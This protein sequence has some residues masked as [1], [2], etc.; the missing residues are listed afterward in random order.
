[1]YKILRR[2]MFKE[3]DV[4]FVKKAIFFLYE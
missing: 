1:M 4:I 3:E 2:N